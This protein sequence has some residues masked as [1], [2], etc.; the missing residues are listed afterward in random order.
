MKKLI[1]LAAMG[2]AGFGFAQDEAEFLIERVQTVVKMRTERIVDKIPEA[3]RQENTRE[4]FDKQGYE[5]TYAVTVVSPGVEIIDVRSSVLTKLQ[6]KD[7]TDI[8]LEAFPLGAWIGSTSPSEDKKHI[9]FA[10]QVEMDKVSAEESPIVE[11]NV[12]IRTVGGTEVKSVKFSKGDTE[13]QTIGTY[14]LAPST[15]KGNFDH[16]F[17]FVMVIKSET[18]VVWDS[19]VKIEIVSGD[20]ILK[21]RGS[22]GFG[23]VS[24]YYF[25]E[26][27]TS[28]FTVNLT[29]WKNL[30]EQTVSFK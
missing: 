26:A 13:P 6:M 10:V 15:K 24:E 3:F 22:S 2:L 28:D 7:G 20:K 9:M 21:S 4:F 16:G 27:P 5:I 11:G 29:L 1:M 17:N 18:G 25:D 19:L 23:K 14:T 8:P 12:A 30:K